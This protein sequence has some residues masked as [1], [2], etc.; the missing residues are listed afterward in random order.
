MLWG[1]TLMAFISAR[2]NEGG[3]GLTGVWP[4]KSTVAT[5]WRPKVPRWWIPTRSPIY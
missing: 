5:C 3:H 4:G 2:R 1:E